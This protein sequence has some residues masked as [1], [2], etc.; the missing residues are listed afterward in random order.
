MTCKYHSIPKKK[1]PEWTKEN[2][3]WFSGNDI[4]QQTL[5]W[6]KWSIICIRL[7]LRFQSENLTGGALEWV[8]GVRPHPQIFG[9][10]WGA[11]PPH[12]DYLLVKVPIF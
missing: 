11:P 4:S 6:E 8:R 12:N 10:G 3:E 5:T 7:V 9:S 2:P 1:I